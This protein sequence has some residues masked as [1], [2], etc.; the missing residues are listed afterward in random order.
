[1]KKIL[2]ITLRILGSLVALAAL[3]IAILYFNG[4]A[5]F[6]Q[7]FDFVEAR[8]LEIPTSPEALQV[9]E[10]WAETLCTNCHASN[11][12][13]RP[14]IE[15]DSIGVIGSPNLTSGP[16]GVGA[17]YIDSDWVRALRHGIA[18]NNTPLMGMPSDAFYYMND[19][20]LGA[21]IA[22]LKSV[23][24]VDNPVSP[25]NL[26]PLAFIL[27]SIGAF[28]DVFPAEHIPHDQIP[29]VPAPGLSEAYGQYIVR[30]GDC[31][32]CHGPDLSGGESPVP[33]S[34]PGPN[35]TPGG[36][37]IF[38]TPEEF[39]TTMRTGMTPYGRQLDPDFMPWKE[40]DNL[41]DEELGAILVYLQ[42]LPALEN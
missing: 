2:I 15:D 10:K 3:G 16:G 8:A 31:D 28:G 40:Y 38:W 9:G 18:P 33:G 37:V 24:A 20:D 35:I 6:E 42:S 11:L 5:R 23:H 32:N 19:E 7:Q 1:M 34:P 14:L 4:K 30:V 21:L 41:S 36:P 29:P 26:K 39:I 25:T 13:G 17:Y 12:S 27:I 22:Y